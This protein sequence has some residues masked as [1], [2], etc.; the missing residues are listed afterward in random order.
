M[1]VFFFFDFFILQICC[2]VPSMFVFFNCF[3]DFLIFMFSRAVFLSLSSEHSIRRLI[4]ITHTH[5]RTCEFIGAFCL[6]IF[7]FNLFFPLFAR[8]FFNV[9]ANST[10]KCRYE[11]WPNKWQIQFAAFENTFV[12]LSVSAINKK[13]K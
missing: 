1:I 13:K 12:C 7:R 9:R 2:F 6:F 5:M 4:Q 11:I 10:N 3:S 8:S